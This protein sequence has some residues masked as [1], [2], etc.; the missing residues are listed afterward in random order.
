LAGAAL[1][2][3]EPTPF[4]AQGQRHHAP[5]S[6]ADGRNELPQGEREAIIDC[7]L[8]ALDDLGFP[9]FKALTV[10][11]NR[12][13]LCLWCFD[14]LEINGTDLR[15]QPLTRRR[16][17]LKTLVKRCNHERV[18]LSHTFEDPELLL[19]TCEKLGVEGVVSKRKT[20]KYSSGPTRDWVKVKTTA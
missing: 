2:R 18:R 14:L 8:V 3:P 10:G 12:A 16:L 7:A 15:D 4:H 11:G 9:D 19:E 13:S 17:R 20:S 6:S 1:R 5:V